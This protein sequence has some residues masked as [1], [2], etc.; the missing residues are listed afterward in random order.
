MV[1]ILSH[2]TICYHSNEV[3]GWCTSQILRHDLDAK[4]RIKAY[5]KMVDVA[6]RL[7]GLRCFDMLMALLS[8]INSSA[9]QRL[10][11]TVEGAG[12]RTRQS[13]SRLNLLMSHEQS[14]AT[15]RAALKVSVLPAVPYVGRFL[16]D[17]TFV[18]LGNP[19]TVE[20]PGA[21][22]SKLVNFSKYDRL[23]SVCAGVRRF[24]RE[25]YPFV[26]QP[27]VRTFLGE[28]EHQTP[29]EHYQ[30]SQFLEPTVAE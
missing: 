2:V 29:E 16:T 20:C 5:I 12:S 1:T 9:V 6:K 27:S 21:T 19:D 7:K 24:Q 22:G 17:A 3:S 10:H 23:Y 26:S 4:C 28:F 11:S 14:F 13:L 30:L 18:K 8:A 15:Y 25:R